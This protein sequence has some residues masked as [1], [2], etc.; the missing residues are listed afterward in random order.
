MFRRV[1]CT[2]TVL[3]SVLIALAAPI[4][5][6]AAQGV[7]YTLT[8]T[9]TVFEWNDKL[10]IENTELWG[11]RLAYNFGR[12]I[13]LQGYYLWRDDV[14]TSLATVSDGNLPPASFTEQ[15]LDIRKYG[16]DV[17]L[18]LGTSGVTPFLKGG[19]GV[20]EFDTPDGDPVKAIALTAGGGFR[21]GLNRLNIEVF[22]ED[23]AF[24]IDRYS[25]VDLANPPGPADPDAEKIRHNL[26]FGAGVNLKL[27]GSGG[28]SAGETDDAVATRFRSGLSGLSLAVEPFVGRLEFNEDLGLDRQE[29]AGVRT[30]FDLGRYVGLRGYYW[31]GINRDFDDTEPIQSW[32][33]EARFNLSSGEGAIPYLVGGA[34]H[35]DFMDEYVDEAGLPR[36]DETVLIFGGGLGFTVGNRFKVDVFARNHMMAGQDLED[37]SDPDDLFSSWMFGA[38][39]GFNL[40]GHSPDGRRG[41]LAPASA[42]VPVPPAPA[43]PE[44]VVVVKE[45]PVAPERAAAVADSV[46]GEKRAAPETQTPGAIKKEIRSYADERTVTIPVPTEGEIY[47]RYGTPGAVTI[48]SQAGE[49]QTAPE[50]PKAPPAPKSETGAA[51]PALD[52]EALRAI[53]RD[54]LQRSDL[55]RRSEAG[56]GITAEDLEKMQDRLEEKIEDA[57]RPDAPR[58]SEDGS[59]TVTVDVAGD[60]REKGGL[61][62]HGFLPYLGFQLDDPTM[63]VLGGRVDM[64]PVTENSRIHWEPEFAWSSGSDVTTLLFAANLN[65]PIR[66]VE[67][68]GDWTPFVSLGGG[69]LRASNGDSETDLV[70][71]AAWGVEAKFDK[72]RLFAEHQ[73]IKFFDQNRL[74]VGIRLG[75]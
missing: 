49:K 39:I 35:I 54:E 26:T 50:A 40:F 57:K 59:S 47:I 46:A 74:L 55:D 9:Y 28:R 4:V 14:K 29:L 19:G 33:G 64:G 3:M 65:L 2:V 75:N 32:G 5:P 38:G 25:L 56:E 34:G 62:V 60:G 17:I 43:V 72:W 1:Q 58:R 41:F 10:G 22:A 30:G 53:I 63:F 6:A 37:V 42:V 15:E 66:K 11:G 7:T 68:K 48:E 18:N 20:L 21:F 8:P 24:R 16:A 61:R 52:T 71:N 27:G 31:R 69:L 44:T 73:G 51:A 12:Y 45:V 13:S 23:T 70:I 67:D 36:D